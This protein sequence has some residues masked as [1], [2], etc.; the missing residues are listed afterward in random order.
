MLRKTNRKECDNH[1]SEK[2]ANSQFKTTAM[3][4]RMGNEIRG[5]SGDRSV[6][7]GMEDLLHNARWYTVDQ[8]CHGRSTETK[9]R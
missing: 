2:N 9:E 3:A 5:L 7:E 4:A 1:D 6:I 8:G